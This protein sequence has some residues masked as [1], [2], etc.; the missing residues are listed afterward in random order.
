VS[1]GLYLV[2]AVIFG[3]IKWV[4]N[5]LVVP[6][7]YATGSTVGPAWSRVRS[8]I[9]APYL[10]AVVL[11]W[12]ARIGVGIVVAVVALTAILMTCCIAVLPYIGAVI[13]LPL[14]VLMTSWSMYFVDQFG[15]S[16]RIFPEEEAQARAGQ[17]F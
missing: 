12:L 2:L 14:S 17:V 9:L 10:G 4:L 6:T 16:F 15:E 5:Q 3:T 7:M 13:L 11:F 8:E 1:F